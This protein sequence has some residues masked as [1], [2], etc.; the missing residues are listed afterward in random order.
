M[1]TLSLSASVTDT[2]P[3]T[4]AQLY[5]PASTPGNVGLCLSGGGTRACNAAMGQLR[6]LANIQA[7]GTSLLSQIRVL[8]TVSGGSWLGVPYQYMPSAGPTDPDYLGTYNSNQGALTVA[9]LA[10]LPNGNAG[11]PMTTIMFSLEGIAGTA[12][13]LYELFQTL[14]PNNPL[15][16]NMLWQ[17]VMG[18]NIL[19]SYN[20]FDMNVQAGGL[21]Q[22]MFSATKASLQGIVNANGSLSSQTAYLFADQ[23]GIS[24]TQ[25]PLHICNMGMF[26]S[27]PGVSLQLLVPV[28]ANG[29]IAGVVGK[30]ANATD[31]N[32]LPVGGGGVQSFAY[33]SS[34][35]SQSGDVA[36]VTQTRQW[37]LV[38]IMGTSSAAFAEKVKNL[39]AEWKSDKAKFLEWLAKEGQAILKWIEDHLPFELHAHAKAIVAR[40]ALSVESV[41]DFNFPNPDDLVPQYPSWPV[42]DGAANPNPNT[43]ADGGSLE[44]TGLASLLAY[45]DIG[46]AIVCVNSETAMVQGSAGISNGQGG[47]VSGTMVV[48]DDAVPP[49]F[50]YQPY[51]ATLGYVPYSSGNV[52]PDNQLFGNNQVFASSEFAG[53][54]IG[55]WE[56]A[57]SAAPATQPA[58]LSQSLTVQGNAWF[59]VT[60]GS[61]PITI[62]WVYL[63]YASDWGALFDNNQPVQQIIDAELSA[64]QFPHYDTFSTQLSATQINLLAH[65]A[66]WSLVTAE[67]NG[68]VFSSLFKS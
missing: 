30:P 18:L 39:I 52:S 9:D 28:Q 31:A 16:A 13:L 47:W 62:V 32:G 58:I 24:R 26:V 25:R 29:L 41:A 55:L 14:Q 4:T 12:I 8:S 20:L 64:H 67:Q 59:G 34:F 3:L 19:D 65:L 17:T 1:T 54:L 66:S 46:S 68:G 15:P 53:F 51:D 35:A 63:N 27:V 7:N 22:D 23:V 2:P 60:A 33:N 36:T 38:D 57:G 11:N 61:A 5:A 48:V 56:A 45:G 40:G 42:A 37:S 43:Y 44:N 49:L 50:G 6:A 10:S 21:P